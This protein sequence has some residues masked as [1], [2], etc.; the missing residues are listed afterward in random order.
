MLCH[1]SVL[2]SSLINEV[3][4]TQILAKT[5]RLVASG[6][7][8]WQSGMCLVSSLTSL[9][10]HMWQTVLS[11]QRQEQHVSVSRC[12]HIIFGLQSHLFCQIEV[13][14]IYTT[15]ESTSLNPDEGGCRKKTLLALLGCNKE[16]EVS[17]LEIF[18]SMD[19]D[20]ALVVLFA[21]LATLCNSKS[22]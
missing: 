22:N 12:L 8:G 3:Q 19:S 13:A 18:R 7:S 10:Q 16:D 15:I 1:A 21:K 11:K 6:S 4:P 20:N 5:Y 17:H 2:Q 14:L 9:V